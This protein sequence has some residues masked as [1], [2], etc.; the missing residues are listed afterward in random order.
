MQIMGVRENGNSV[1]FENNSTRVV[2][3][4]NI[5]FGGC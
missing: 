2:V 4:F 1:L 3:D 5:C